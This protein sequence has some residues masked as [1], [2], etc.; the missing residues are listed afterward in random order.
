MKTIFSPLKPFSAAILLSALTPMLSSAVETS[1][2]LLAGDGSFETGL[3]SWYSYG[4][5]MPE[6]VRTDAVDGKYALRI[7]GAYE[8]QTLCS[9]FENLLKA[10]RAYVLSFYAKGPKGSVMTVSGNWGGRFYRRITL[11]GAWERHSVSISPA[12]QDQ[13]LQIGFLAQKPDRSFLID[14]LQLEEG[15]R[16]S[17]YTPARAL[18]LA[19]GSG[20][21]GEVC[22]ADKPVVLSATVRNNFLPPDALPL[23]AVVSCSGLKTMT[24][25][26]APEKGAVNTVLFGALDLPPGYYPAHLVITGADGQVWGRCEIPFAVIRPTDPPRRESFFGIHGSQMPT[27]LLRKIGAAWNF[28]SIEPWRW[29]NPEKGRYPELLHRNAVFFEGMQTQIYCGFSNDPPPWAVLPD[30]K[31]PDLNAFGPFLAHML[32]VWKDVPGD[33]DSLNEGDHLLLRLP[34]MTREKAAAYMAETLRIM[35]PVV[36]KAGRALLFNDSGAR[37]Q[38]AKRVFE[39]APDCFD[40]Y[41]PH[42]YVWRR[43]FRE[44]EN[45]YVEIPEQ[46]TRRELDLAMELIRSAGNRHRLV[47]GELGYGFDPDAAY[48][49]RIARRYAAYMARCFL[50]AKKYPKLERVMWFA[51]LFSRCEDGSIYTMW[52]N[53]NGFRPLAIVPAYAHLA[54]LL[55]YAENYRELAGGERRLVRWEKEGFTHFA[56]WQLNGETAQ[57]R[58]AVPEAEVTDVVGKILPGGRFALSQ[59]PV[60]VSVH[61]ELADKVEERL[62]REVIGSHA[63][64]LTLRPVRCDSLMLMAVNRLRIPGNL[65]VTINQR[66]QEI[67]LAPNGRRELFWRIPQLAPEGGTRLPYVVQWPD[68]KAETRHFVSEPYLKILPMR[69]AWETLHF[70]PAATIL[71]DK[72]RHVLPPD[73]QIDWSGPEDLSVRAMLAA[74]AG[75][76]YLFAEVL[77]DEHDN[78]WKNGDI[79]KGDSIQF[80]LDMKNDAVPDAEPDPDNDFEF[81]MAAGQPG[82]WCFSAP[83]G[84]KTGVRKDIP[85]RVVRDGRRTVYRIA[86]PWKLLCGSKPPRGTIFRFSLAV[87]DRDRGVCNYHMAFG[88][89]IV[90]DKRPDQYRAVMLD[91]E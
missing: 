22:Y 10:G 77:D 53:E 67:S 79:W 85:V 21:T 3:G 44:K 41:A 14:A 90:R 43:H 40:V 29:N 39:L 17:A 62:L 28:R 27:P 5:S 58:S 86:L 52:K 1:R 75:F 74:D 81:G 73:P 84:E 9:S 50:L 60:Y 32:E 12:S 55:D 6:R 61:R 30:T 83:K 15:S 11:S 82:V 63:V 37:Q 26:L 71:L 13:F 64:D 23:T 91:V 4:P 2:N 88:D 89:G 8:S 65:S 49:S 20:E 72:R 87:H 66:K 70:S 51:A 46:G 24:R 54:R 7:T 36:K 25:T 35:Y 68:G 69:G 78:P 31:L 76:L 57:A 34:G 80:A 47:I 38:Y 33:V 59:E 16:A 18:D 19:A 56:L 45:R 48:D 42:P